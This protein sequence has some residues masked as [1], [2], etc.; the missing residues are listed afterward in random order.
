MTGV[1]KP[2]A[3]ARHRVRQA[4]RGA[5]SADCTIARGVVRLAA[6]VTPYGS[7]ETFAVDGGDHVG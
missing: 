7:F 4:K 1:T 2:V 6:L 3:T 5:P